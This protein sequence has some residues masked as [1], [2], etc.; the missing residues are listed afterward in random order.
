MNFK[1]AEIA[2]VNRDHGS[3][4]GVAFSSCGVF[5]IVSTCSLDGFWLTDSG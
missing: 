4:T 5:V 2:K 3:L 1:R